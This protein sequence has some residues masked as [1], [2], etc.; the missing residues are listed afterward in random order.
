V[1]E[2]Q[3]QTVPVDGTLAAES[4]SAPAHFASWLTGVDGSVEVMANPAGVGVGS[5]PLG[6]E[7]PAE[8]FSVVRLN[9]RMGAG[10]SWSLGGLVAD[11]QSTAWRMAAEF[12]I[13]PGGGHQIQAGSGYGTRLFQPLVSGDSDGRSDNRSVGAIFVQDRWQATENVAYTAG[14]RF[15]YI[16]FL[17]ER[18]H[19]DP[20]TGFEVKIDD[21]SRVRGTVATRTIVPGG[22]LLTLSVM[23][24]APAMAFAVIDDALR[25]ERAT[26]YE[27]AVDQAVGASTVTARAFFEDV[28]DQLVN[29]FGGPGEAGTL[30][31]VNGGDLAARGMGLTVARRFGDRL[32]GSVSYTYGHSWRKEPAVVEEAGAPPDVFAY[33]DADFHDI[34]TRVETFIDTTDT[35][36]IA[37]YRLNRLSPEVDGK[38]ANTVANTWFDVQLRQGLPFLGNLTRAEWEVLLAVRNLFYEP[39]EGAVLDEVAVLNPPKRVLGGISVRF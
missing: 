32:S 5:V 25:A 13:E 23:G 2:D 38:K 28:D 27:V 9:G 17:D 24:S 15:S 18:N 34:V 3:G 35:R 37:F 10:G 12:I 8:S 26:H 31:I 30:R 14:A 20:F 39:T 6:F 16:G 1:L 21:R 7:S 22:D 33:E 11:S 19:V 36:V 4:V 29:A